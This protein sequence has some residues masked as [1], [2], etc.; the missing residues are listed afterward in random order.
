MNSYFFASLIL[1]WTINQLLVLKEPHVLGCVFNEGLVLRPADLSEA[2]AFAP[3]G[4]TSLNLLFAQL[5]E[6]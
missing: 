3:T 2:R 5:V 6:S 4:P 1:Q